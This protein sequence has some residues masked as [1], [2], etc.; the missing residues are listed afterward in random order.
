MAPSSR[1]GQAHSVRLSMPTWPGKGLRA[2]TRHTPYPLHLDKWIS[3]TS[4]PITPCVSKCRFRVAWMAFVTTHIS[5]ADCTIRIDGLEVVAVPV[6]TVAVAGC[7]GRW[8]TRSSPF[9]SA[10]LYGP[11]W[12]LMGQR[13]MRPYRTSVPVFAARSPDSM[14]NWA[15]SGRTRCLARQ[16]SREGGTPSFCIRSTT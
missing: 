6:R 3:I 10:A 11:C 8:R 12:G 16:S 1:L 5:L 13:L 15:G 14:R 2:P 9:R 7:S 4:P